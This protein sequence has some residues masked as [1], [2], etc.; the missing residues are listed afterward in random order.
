MAGLLL[1]SS[2]SWDMSVSSTAL[3]RQQRLPRVRMAVAQ[4]VEYCHLQLNLA[5]SLPMQ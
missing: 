1:S 3:S 4:G 5:L 2:F